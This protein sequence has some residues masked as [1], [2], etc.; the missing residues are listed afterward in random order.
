MSPTT[1]GNESRKKGWRANGAGNYTAGIHYFSRAIKE[2]DENTEPKNVLQSYK[3]KMLCESYTG[4]YKKALDTGKKAKQILQN[5]LNEIPELERIKFL[6][7]YTMALSKNGKYRKAKDI[8]KEIFSRSEDKYRILTLQG[9]ANCNIHL[10]NY[11]KALNFFDKAL[12]K[13]PSHPTILYLKE[14]KASCLHRTGEYSKAISLLKSVVRSRKRQNIPRDWTYYHLGS[15]LYANGKK[16]E[17]YSNFKKADKYTDTLISRVQDSNFRKSYFAQKLEIYDRLVETALEL[18]KNSD[19]YYYARISKGKIFREKILRNNLSKKP[20]E[21]L[22]K[23]ETLLKEMRDLTR[24]ETA[25]PEKV[26]KLEKEY[27]KIARTIDRKDINSQFTRN[28]LNTGEVQ[29]LPDIREAIVEFYLL[30]EKTV[31]FA[32][33]RSYF[34]TYVYPAGRKEVTKYCRNIRNII[35]KNLN[36]TG[37]IYKWYTKKLYDKILKDLLEDLKNYKHIIFSPHRALHKMPFGSVVL[38]DGSYLIDNFSI[39]YAPSP[40]ILSL[41]KGKKES[42]SRKFLG[43]GDTLGDLPGAKKEL[44]AISN[45]FDAEVT[46]TGENAGFETIKEKL[47]ESDTVHFSCHGIFDSDNPL[48]SGLKIYPKNGKEKITAED[49]LNMELP[50]LNTAVL[51]C[52]SSALGSD[53]AGD[54]YEGLTR[55]LLASGCRTLLTTLWEIPDEQTCSIMKDFYKKYSEGTSPSEAIHRAILNIKENFEDPFYWA[56]FK[57]TG[58]Y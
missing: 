16:K 49:F 5:H 12:H 10:K 33:T 22:E 38:K 45:L 43:V 18:G 41:V 36:H 56:S 51:S 55:A 50:E 52:C 8:L 2:L 7:N 32:I 4:Q 1:K 54:D 14:Q 9:L 37:K 58:R 34:K 13:S 20:R 40:L 15:S 35:V 6:H 44:D 48:Q 23:E 31:I 24:N 42:T 17:A 19:A 47:K 21:I 46:L 27:D 26:R 11:K 30:P 39:S 28:P 25:D 29:K 57:L 3:G 53:D